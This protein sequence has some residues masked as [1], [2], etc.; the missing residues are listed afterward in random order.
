MNLKNP[1]NFLKHWEH[2]KPNVKDMD[3]PVTWV[4]MADIKAYCEWSGGSLPRDF[5]W[6]YVAGN[7]IANTLYPWGSEPKYEYQGNPSDNPVW[8]DVES[9]PEGY[10]HPP[11]NYYPYETIQKEM[12]ELADVTAYESQASTIQGVAQLCSNAWEYTDVFGD[13][14]MDR[15]ILRGGAS[16]R[17]ASTQDLSEQWYFP[18]AY[19]N[20]KHNTQ[21]LMSDSMDRTGNVTFRCCYKC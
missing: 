21:I 17:P 4:C 12:S 9:W 14:R 7:G 3:K 5:E 2:R 13:D 18:P 16:Y 6:Q 11:A 19:E 15:A 20:N 10:V 8:M 1:Y